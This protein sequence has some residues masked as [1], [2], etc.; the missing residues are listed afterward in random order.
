MLIKKHKETRGNTAGHTSWYLLG[1]LLVYR[2]YN[3][4]N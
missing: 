2:V 3:N 1:F 4:C